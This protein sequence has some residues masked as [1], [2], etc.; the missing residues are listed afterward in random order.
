MENPNYIQNQGDLSE[1]AGPLLS[2]RAASSQRI[3]FARAADLVACVAAAAADPEL[4]LVRVKNSLD[5][6]HDAR[7]AA[8]FRSLPAIARSLPRTPSL[9]LRACPTP[10]PSDPSPSNPTQS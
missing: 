7:P 3:V 2:A 6:A 1:R 8:G 5:P 4:D 10:N 9:S